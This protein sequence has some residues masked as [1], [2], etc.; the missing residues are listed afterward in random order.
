MNIE[1]IEPILYNSK[2]RAVWG[3]KNTGTGR[4]QEVTVHTE[5]V[6]V[7]LHTQLTPTQLL[8]FSS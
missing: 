3:R 6:A 7:L 4:I 8:E 2:T 1:D 5:K